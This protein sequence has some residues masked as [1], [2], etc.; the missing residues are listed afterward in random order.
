MPSEHVGSLKWAESFIV[1]KFW[2]P[3]NLSAYAPM[4]VRNHLGKKHRN[5]ILNAIL[6]VENEFNGAI[7]FRCCGEIRHL[8]DHRADTIEIRIREPPR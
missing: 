8:S 2:Y 5:V 7:E 1:H 6:L 3:F 4:K